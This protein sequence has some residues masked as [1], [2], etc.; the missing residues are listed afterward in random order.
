MNKNKVTSIVLVVA[1]VFLAW[2]VLSL[3]MADHLA[4]SNPEK[5]LFWRSN[6]PEALFR[7]AEKELS[8]KNWA[9]AKEH[10]NNALRAN[11]LDG[12]S[13]RVLA[14]VAEQQGNEKQVYS[15]FSK[16]VKLSPRDV[17]SHV[18]LLEFALRNQQAAP[19]VVHLDALLRVKPGLMEALLPQAIALAVNPVAQNAMLEQLA[20]NPP[21]R[22]HL[23]MG[24]AT[25]KFSADQ[26]VP[27]FTKLHAKSKLEPAD[28]LPLINRLN[29]ENRY[30]Q[31]YLTW[32]NLIP[33][34]QRKYL[35]NVF[36]GGFELPIEEQIGSFAWLV[37]EVT[38][39]QL[40]LLN[41]RGTMGE[42]S[43]YVEFEGRRTPF[44][45]L[46]QILALPSGQWQVSYRAKA[47]RLE[48]TRGL[49]W[50]V[51]CQSNG[52]ILADSEPMKGQFN[53]QEL[54]FEFSVP[55]NCAGQRLILMIPA[56]I[57]A[58]T[59]INGSLWLDNVIIQRVELIL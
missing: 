40:Q 16:A 41:S 26:I 19:A 38:G 22:R 48:N 47:D 1:F 7:M 57:P 17:I 49:V 28:Y 14:Q 3:G 5:A 6:H 53:W 45:H 46:S 10:A 35:G 8:A 2:R 30:A 4:V 54:K 37:Q 23:L 21:W 42:N 31:S 32:A 18:W 20:L 58:E 24:L 39:A 59:L 55:D 56:R 27:V 34:Q 36:D 9:Q 51:V 29:N 44:A 50:R 43:F 12:R 15:L 25:S 52:S 13:L 33:I 11:P